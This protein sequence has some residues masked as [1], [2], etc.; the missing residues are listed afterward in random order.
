MRGP[1]CQGGFTPLTPEV[2]GEALGRSFT[3]RFWEKNM[4][5]RLDRRDFLKI[6]GIGA[7][8]AAAA[9]SSCNR[10]E[11]QFAP[12]DVDP[13]ALP[14]TLTVGAPTLDFPATL[15]E[16]DA[17]LSALQGTLAEQN[18][19][20][21]IKD[22]QIVDFQ[23]VINAQSAKATE[24]SGV[25]AARISE[26][27]T[28]VAVWDKIMMVLNGKDVRDVYAQEGDVFVVR[29]SDGKTSTVTYKMVNGVICEIKA[30]FP[31]ILPT[32]KAP[33]DEPEEPEVPEDEK[34][35][36][37]DDNTPVPPPTQPAPSP[38]PAGQPVDFGDFYR[39]F[40]QIT[41]AGRTSRLGGR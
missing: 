31:C 17:R 26:L 39:R 20:L 25:Q 29:Y 18:A 38:A 10:R 14:P 24:E 15:A 33:I 35:P 4:E 37:P 7:G 32:K 28:K 8:A 34:T 12:T 40:K 13:T 6:L 30:V 23:E 16:K 3:P 27:E 2:G 21:I 41:S 19:R 5:G 36:T 22:G 1:G 11:V 9:M